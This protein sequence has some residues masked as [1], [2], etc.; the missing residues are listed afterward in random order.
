VVFIDMRVSRSSDDAS[1]VRVIAPRRCLEGDP[2]PYYGTY[3]TL[4]RAHLQIP[5]FLWFLLVWMVQFEDCM[6][7]VLNLGVRSGE[8]LLDLHLV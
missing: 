8:A 7:Y 2:P 1:P 5:I 4:A 3:P 6:S